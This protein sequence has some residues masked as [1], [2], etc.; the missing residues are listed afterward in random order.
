MKP[1]K[2]VMSSKPKPPQGV[3]RPAATPNRPG[4][5]RPTTKP[6]KKGM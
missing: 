5:P 2:P 1:G 3:K 4:T 6:V